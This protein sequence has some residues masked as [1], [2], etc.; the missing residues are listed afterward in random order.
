MIKYRTATAF[1]LASLFATQNAHS[2]CN[3]IQSVEV[4]VG[5]KQ[6]AAW[7][8]VSNEVHSLVMA[9]GF[10][11]GLKVE[12]ASR[13]SQEY[14]LKRG[15]SN[16]TTE[17]LRISV[18]DLSG[19][20]PRLMTYSFGGVNSKQG[21]TPRGGAARIEEV[22]EPGITLNLFR[23]ACLSAAQVAALPTAAEL[24]QV[25]EQIQPNAQ[26]LKGQEAAKA[27]AANGKL[28]VNYPKGALSEAEL[29]I[30]KSE[31]EKAGVQFQ[32]RD[33]EGDAATRSFKRGYDSAMMDAVNSKLGEAKSRE[34]ER[35]IK[36]RMAELKQK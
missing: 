12:Q 5:E 7:K 30:V 1:C 16:T 28:L 9:N 3:A 8:G 34:M 19:D 17:L 24:N 36:A 32:I 20:K 13:E 10:K 21:Y 14:W 18:Y 25:E 22:G 33:D 4:K 11:V 26:E 2:E 6:I 27:D 31:V 29:A 15:K 23:Q 35:N